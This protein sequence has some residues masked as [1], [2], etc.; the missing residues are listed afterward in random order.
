MLKKIAAYMQKYQMVKAGDHI[1]VGVSGGADSVCLFLVLEEL[2]HTMGFSLSVIHIEHGIR[3]ME[4]L[5]DM[6]FVKRLAESYGVLFVSKSYPVEEMAKEQGISVEEA[7]R[8]A[9][10][11]A[12]EEERKRFGLI[13]NTQGGA[14]KTAVAHHGDD[15]AETM[16]F[17]LCRGSGLD[18]LAGIR[19]VRGAII[20]PLLCVTR[21]EIEYFLKEQKQ[22]YCTD[23]TNSDIRYSR[24]RIRNCI[25]PQLAAINEA[26]TAHMNLLAQDL[27]EI[28][29]FLRR[30]VDKVL[31]ERMEK[32]GE[33]TF[34]FQTEG[35]FEY[36]SFLQKQVMLGL[37]EKA[38]GS[39]KDITREHAVSLLSLACGQ[40]GRRISLP[41]GIAAENS[42][43]LLL[44][45]PYAKDEKGESIRIPIE[46]IWG[47]KQA[48]G[49]VLRYRVF[50]MPVKKDVKIPKNLYTKWFDYDKIK[51]R[52]YLRT[53]EPG[54]YFVLDS[55]GHRQ[56]L[57]DYWINEK[58]PKSR[59]DEILLL[60]DGHHV[61]WAAGYRISAY[62]KITEHTKR[63]L[64]VQLMEEEA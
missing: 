23:A 45:F 40:T 30:E 43:G 8:A 56:K 6:C 36:P 14:V 60:A 52:L 37:M 62:Y 58:V 47:E 21:K 61:L 63:V 64:E 39:R 4:S 28:S 53:R 55:E 51:N 11:E 26:S 41:Y 15:N 34:C 18:G 33:R 46:G 49:S 54:D 22:E 44:L 9:R 27:L 32:K 13:C 29:A 57:K 31:E 25:M 59:R 12:F 42:Y 7:G 24:N 50:P 35:F 19:P 48:L 20:R 2:R 17:H 3:G 38:C 1:C 16:L 10:Y 5:D